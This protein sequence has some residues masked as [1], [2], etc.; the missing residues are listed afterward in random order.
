[1][2]VCDDG[3]GARGGLDAGAGGA[4]GGALFSTRKTCLRSLP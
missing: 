2:G 1:V 4:G 3:A